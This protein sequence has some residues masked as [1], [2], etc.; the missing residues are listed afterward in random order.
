MKPSQGKLGLEIK[1]AWV[2]LIEY[3]DTWKFLTNGPKFW[4]QTLFF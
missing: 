2:E 3:L 4:V 1:E